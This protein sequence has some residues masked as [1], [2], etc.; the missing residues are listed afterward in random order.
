MP[1]F[2]QEFSVKPALEINAFVQ[3]FGGSLDDILCEQFERT[4]NK[5]NTVSFKGRTLQIPGDEYR[6]HYV[7]TKIRIHQYIDGHLAIFHGPRKLAELEPIKPVKNSIPELPLPGM[8]V[9]I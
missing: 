1:A 6:H 8:K 7:K 3:W 2:N 4:V 9:A 5:D